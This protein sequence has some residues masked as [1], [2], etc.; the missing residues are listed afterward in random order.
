M[1][2]T[3]SPLTS[4]N[5]KGTH[6]VCPWLEE[7]PRI[8]TS[9]LCFE[10]NKNTHTHTPEPALLD[11]LQPRCP[12]TQIPA[13]GFFIGQSFGLKVCS[14]VSISS[15][16]RICPLFHVGCQSPSA[17]SLVLCIQPC[18]CSAPFAPFSLPELLNLGHFLGRPF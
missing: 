15:S 17:L 9:K 14:A 7:C 8:Y 6:I 16:V 10:K 3:G 5:K 1:C 12:H 18:R 13:E 4:N 2:W 11:Q